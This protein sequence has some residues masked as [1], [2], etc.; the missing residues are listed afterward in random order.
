[1]ISESAVVDI[2]YQT[3]WNNTNIRV[4]VFEKIKA[5]V[6]KVKGNTLKRGLLGIKGI[7]GIKKMLTTKAYIKCFPEMHQ[8]VFF[9][10]KKINKKPLIIGRIKVLFFLPITKS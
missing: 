1:M 2:L 6:V 4:P 5:L 7:K 3:D 9:Q 8:L 10:R